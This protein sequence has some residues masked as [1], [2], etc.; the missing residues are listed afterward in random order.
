MVCKYLL[1]RILI[2]SWSLRKFLVSQMELSF[3]DARTS[4]LVDFASQEEGG[5]SLVVLQS[6][7]TALVPM[8]DSPSDLCKVELGVPSPTT[9]EAA[10]TGNLSLSAA[11][12]MGQ[13][14]DPLEEQRPLA[15]ASG[16]PSSGESGSKCVQ[17]G[18]SRSRS[19]NIDANNPRMEKA[20]RM[21]RKR[22]GDS[23]V[24]SRY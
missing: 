4:E 22:S 8:A 12:D 13:A 7:N 23:G 2:T 19:P 5:S 17:S 16:R 10:Q 6:M 15:S 14:C 18:M 24:R 3:L 11:G 9:N 1:V 21:S 20:R